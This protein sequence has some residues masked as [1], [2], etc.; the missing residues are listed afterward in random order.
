MDQ[1]ATP[2]YTDLKFWSFIISILAL[3]LSQQSF[4]KNLFR[5]ARISVEPYDQMYLTHGFGCPNVQVHLLATNIGGRKV[6]VK[7]ISLAI[8]K[9]NGESFAVRSI[10]YFQKQGDPNAILLTPF[11]LL[12]GD[13]WS[14]VIQFFS[15]MQ[16]QEDKVIRQATSALRADIS[17]KISKRGEDEPK[18]LVYADPALVEPFIRCFERHFKWHPDEYSMTISMDTEPPNAFANRQFR[19]V[20][21]EADTHDMKV[22][23]DKYAS[24]EGVYYTQP[25]TVRGVFV[26]IQKGSE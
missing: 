16:R 6:R 26:P 3:L 8:L 13:E 19:F 4:F 25:E 1:I 10:S 5:G 12:P 18:T 17:A 7:G 2:F 23:V 20:L 21:F 9:S 11:S 14:H 22:I 24:G 15:P